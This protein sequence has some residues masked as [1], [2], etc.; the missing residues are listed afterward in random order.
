[1]LYSVLIYDSEA[2]IGELPKEKLDTLI[3]R[4]ERVQEQLAAEGK[5]GPVVRL[6]PTMTATTLHRKAEHVITDG[7]FA[8]TKEQL[9]GFYI[10]DCESM[11]EA[12]DAARL[13]GGA[14]DAHTLEIRPVSLYYPNEKPAPRRNTR[15]VA[16]IFP[17][18]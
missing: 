6:M 13:I 17:S 2:V 8:E 10:V 7:P 12:Q 16:P 1:M 18:D 3:A 15:P 11:E 9:L 4:H 14:C 5:L